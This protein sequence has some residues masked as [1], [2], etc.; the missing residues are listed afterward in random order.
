MDSLIS[1]TVI[2][3]SHI[4]LTNAQTEALLLKIINYWN[5][6]KASFHKKFVLQNHFYNDNI[7]NAEDQELLNILKKNPI[8]LF[9]PNLNQKVIGYQTTLTS[10]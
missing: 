8:V 6:V 7:L 5:D 4:D 2:N 3:I 9:M 10:H 1:H